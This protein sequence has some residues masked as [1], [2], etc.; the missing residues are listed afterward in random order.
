MADFPKSLP[1]NHYKSNPQDKSNWWN[2]LLQQISIAI[3]KVMTLTKNHRVR[4]QNGGEDEINVAGLSGV[5]ADPQPPITTALVLKADYDANTILKADSDNTPVAL[6]VAEQKVVGRA[7][8]G[9]I[10]ALDIDSDLS[11]VSTSDNTL[12]SAKAVKTV[13]DAITARI[14]QQYTKTKEYTGFSEPEN[15]IVTG[16]GTNRTITL[17]GTVEAYWRGTLNTTIISGW[18]SSAH[19]TDTSKIYYLYYDG[20]T[21]AWYDTVWSFDKLQIALAFYDATLTTWVYQ[22]ECHGFMQHDE[23]EQEHFNTGAWRQSGGDISAYTIGNIID[24][25]PSI[26]Q[27]VHHDEDLETLQAQVV[28]TGSA[29]TRAYLTS[30]GIS[31]FLTGQA[32]I[33]SVSTNQPYYNEYTTEW[34][35]TLMPTNSVMSLWVI[36][37]PMAADT[38]SQKF[39][40]VFGQ[41][42]W[43]TQAQGSSAGQLASALTQELARNFGEMDLGTLSGLTPEFL[44]I[45]RITITYTG[46][47]WYISS[48]SNLNGSR[49]SIVQSPVSGLTS[50]SV[51]AP[52]Y[53]SGTA[54]DPLVLKNDAD[55]ALT[56]FSTDGT[57]GGD[58]DTDIP[59]EK[60]VKTYADGK[61]T[62]PSLTTGT[63]PKAAS[64]STISD[65]IITESSGKIGI[66]DSSPDALLRLTKTHNSGTTE[67]LFKYGFDGNWNM[68]FVQNYV[69]SGDIKQEW[70]QS[71]NGTEYDVIA[72]KTG[73]V[74]IGTTTPAC[75]L[76]VDGFTALGHGNTPFKAHSVSGTSNASEG[77]YTDISSGI[78]STKII[79]Y[80]VILWYTSTGTIQP[81]Y[82]YA[83]G[84]QFHVESYDSSGTG[85]FRVRNHAT[86]SE[87]I[88]SKPITIF[89]F[90]IA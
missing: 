32:T 34:V 28:D 59:T 3:D 82:T 33:V 49:Y 56:S 40:F 4:H 71:Y 83:A 47:N 17:T 73:N 90:Y 86:N 12:P 67:T 60:A 35:Q 23:H 42:Q 30:T 41:G 2:G 64:A 63:I 7:T 54:T 13:T 52:I 18:T 68:R 6:T 61:M 70:K 74:G 66:N 37:I 58:T 38:N 84:Y 31:T 22:R 46:G 50:V 20:S 53:G 21:V 76:D 45:A 11:S 43:I 65:S 79:G 88:L 55:T 24:K 26:S 77:G 8:G 69:G 48:V 5:L 80:S 75:K 87:N 19:G 89:I 78:S 62:K 16:N 51:T 72:F 9:V 27:M 39:R 10:T 14:D 1:Y 36:S 29:Y 81:E 25:Y 85:V 15:V 57:L 44:P